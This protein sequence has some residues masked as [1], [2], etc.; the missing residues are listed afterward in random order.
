M[1]IAIGVLVAFVAV[2]A[3]GTL[4][5]TRPSTGTSTAPAPAP[6][7]SSPTT[8][9]PTTAA[10]LYFS[11]VQTESK[12]EIIVGTKV[13]GP[14]VSGWGAAVGSSWGFCFKGDVKDGA[15]AGVMYEGT[16]GP[17][18]LS[19]FAWDA[20]GSGSEFR[21]LEIGP[22]LSAGNQKL[23]PMTIKEAESAFAS[24]GGLSPA[25]SEEQFDE[26]RKTIRLG[27]ASRK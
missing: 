9:Q 12:Q 25:R 20:T 5:L 22:P 2:V 18:E 27:E 3:L 17:V 15:L 19:P 10:T 23:V 26:C 14:N 7:S 11:T 16:G 4:F 1:W 24:V 13:A 8:A 21:L 6:S